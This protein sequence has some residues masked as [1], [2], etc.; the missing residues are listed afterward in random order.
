MRGSTNGQVI[1]LLGAESTGKTTLARGLQIALAT[2]GHRAVAVAEHLRE[3]CDAH[4]RTPRR[5]EQAAI[6]AEQSQRIAR[7]AADHSFVI[8]DTTALTIAVYSEFIFGD[9]DLY[10]DALRCHAGYALTLLTAPDIAWQADAH[11]RDGAHVREPVDALLRAALSR[12]QLPFS[13]VYGHGPARLHNALA[14]V[15]RALGLDAAQPSQAAPGDSAAR[16][17]WHCERCG[18]PQCERR[19]LPGV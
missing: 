14:A 7:A 1:A 4:G 3:F 17:Q 9:R 6:A 12:A 5:D 11:Q 8:A 15:R 19:L 18:D 16:W 10:A 13:V 2:D